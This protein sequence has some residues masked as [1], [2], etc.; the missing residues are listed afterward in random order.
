MNHKKAEDR[1]FH[2]LRMEIGQP[3]P[4]SIIATNMEQCFNFVKKVGFP[5]IRPA[6]P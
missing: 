2:D 5:V 6:I 4:Q 3:V 1:K